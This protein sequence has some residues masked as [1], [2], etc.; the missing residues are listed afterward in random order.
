MQ[1]PKGSSVCLAVSISLVVVLLLLLTPAFGQAIT[2]AIT[3]VVTDPSGGVIP[4]AE[5]RVR[6]EGTNAEL[7]VLTD[8]TGIYAAERLAVG[9]Y[10]INVQVPGFKTFVQTSLELHVNDRLPVNIALQ[11]GEVSQ[12][13]EVVGNQ[14]RVESKSSDVGTLLDGN[15]IVQMP[16]NGRNIVQLIAF[17]PGVASLLPSTLGVGLSGLTSVYVNGSR[18]SQNNWMIDGADNNDVGSNLALINYVNIDSVGEVKILRSNYNAEFGRSGGAQV[19]VVTKSGNNQFHGSVY[20]FARNDVFDAR[21]FFSYIDRDGDKKADAAVLRYHNFGWTVG[22]P[23]KK[24]KL[25]FFWGEE[26][27]RIRSVRGGGVQN[28]RVATEKQRQGDF[29]EFPSVVIKDPATGT[30]FAG[31]VIPS[32]RIDPFAK[33]LLDRFPAPNAD[34]AVLGSNR[35]FSV[36]TP[37]MRNFREDLVRLDYRPDEKN[38]FYGRFI[39]DTIP[40]E[41]PFGEIFGSNYAAFPG[42]ANTKTDNPGRSLVGTWLWVPTTTLVNELSYNYSRGAI[43]SEIT[44]NGERTVAVPKVFTGNPGDDLLPGI[45]FGSGGY[46]GWNFFGPYDNTYGSH[47]IKDTLSKNLGRHALK[48]GVLYSYE[49][50]NENAA[51]GTNGA[52]NFPGTSTSSFTSAGDAFA[53]FLLGRASSYSETN[54][55]IASHLRFQMWEAFLQDDWTVRSNFTLNLG[56]RWSY[57]LQPTDTQN[58]L[59]NFDPAAFSPSKAYQ[60]G[61]DNLRVIGTGDPLN[62][63]IIAGQNSPFGERV[64]ESH[65]DSIGPRLGFAWDPFKDGKTAIRGGYG[66]YFDRTLV[67]I[68]LQNAFVNPPFAFSA[69]FNASGQA[70]PTLQNP[71]QGTQRKNEALVPN[72]NAMSHDFQ[73]P[74]VQQ[75]SLGVQRQL[76][77]DF[78]VEVAYVGSSG[79]HLLKPVGLNQTLPGTVAPTNRARPY[80]G[81]GNITLRDTS[82]ESRYNS[83]QVE[84]GRRWTGGLQINMNYTFSKAISDSSSDRNTADLP[85]DYRN[86]SVERALTTFDRRHIFGVHY[87]WEVPFFHKAPRIVYNILGGW[88]LTGSTR[89]TSGAPLTI[90]CATNSANSYGG[91][92]LRPNLVGDPEGPRTI[93]EWFTKA[94]FQQPAANTFGN[95]GRSL[96]TGP[97]YA[98]TDLTIGKNFQINERFRLQYRAEFFNAFNRASLSGVGTSLGN[99]SFGTV[100]S[101]GEPRL[102]QMGLKL[103]F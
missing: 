101:A 37:Q 36:A 63:I 93:A 39:K 80:I 82:G 17:Q 81:Y 78:R 59:T 67:G 77:S 26:F 42:I 1:T 18:A 97:G 14:Q 6:N 7:V 5:V 38:T 65:A 45:A 10:T 61:S 44:G 62:G 27:R 79:L 9:K 58:L 56:V 15:Q 100:T 31:N 41:E 2:G 92:S 94:A 55:D 95:A 54:I 24:D 35:N 46:G 87:I 99:T 98:I 72:L 47:R 76:P 52:Y 53:D 83:L 12:T 8:E 64:V 29:S 85:Q 16:L 88:Q 60:I 3:G 102:I 66:V 19:N 74:T 71:Q 49:F 33:A 40:S 69:V 73:I 86:Q 48:A 25:F 22:G 13:V 32:N 28:T 70:V 51:G 43:L 90:T 11:T 75:W 68:A 89:L 57:I 96:V 103:T 34:P 91:G 4:G 23:I 84:L 20:E 50:K 21:N 30:A